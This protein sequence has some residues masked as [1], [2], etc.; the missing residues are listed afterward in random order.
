MIFGVQEDLIRSRLK[1]PSTA[2]IR[3]FVNLGEEYKVG[4]FTVLPAPGEDF[5]ARFSLRIRS[6]SAKFGR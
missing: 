4:H 1:Q 5:P 3:P 2:D 6:F